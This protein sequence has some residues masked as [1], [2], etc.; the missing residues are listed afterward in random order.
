[1]LITTHTIETTATPLVIWNIWQDVDN[2]NCWDHGIETSTLHGPFSVGTK[3]TLK[4]K[5]ASPVQI[6]LTK[7][8]PMKL[9]VDEAKLPLTRIIVSHNL[10]IFNGK[11][12][13]THKI[14][15]KGPLSF[16][17]AF[18]IGR[19]MKKNLPSEMAAMIR[20]AETHDA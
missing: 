20:K 17:F 5:G 9:F 18:V 1:M 6:K 3:G 12:R 13:V 2:W 14:E 11:T 19:K 10:K 15:M 7:I 8:E 16:F 4:P